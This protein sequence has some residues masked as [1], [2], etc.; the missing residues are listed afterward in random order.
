MPRPLLTPLLGFMLLTGC[1][2][3]ETTTVR[4]R[5]PEQVEVMTPKARVALTKE[6]PSSA[7]VSSGEFAQWFSLHPYEVDVQRKPDGGIALR[8]DACA[9]AGWSP[10]RAGAAR[11]AVL[12]QGDG[13]LTATWS[14]SVTSDDAWT[15]VGY[16]T[17]MMAS[18]IGTPPTSICDVHASVA[19]LVP[20]SDVVQVEK[21]STPI[22]PL[23]WGALAVG[24]GLLGVSTFVLASSDIGSFGQR[25][26][27]GFGIALPAILLTGWGA[28]AS[29]APTEQQVSRGAS[30]R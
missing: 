8:C 23:G 29:F 20:A 6:G 17:C 25:A 26:P 3:S 28:W 1:L 12:L 24:I 9:D 19:L 5:D 22:R 4:V 7:T 14:R 30:S 10:N 11:E 27:W 16:D 13:T 15:R 2:R 18:T 21:R